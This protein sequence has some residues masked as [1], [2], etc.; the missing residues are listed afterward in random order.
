MLDERKREQRRHKRQGRYLRA[1]PDGLFRIQGR[2]RQ[3]IK[4]ELLRNPGAV[5]NLDTPFGYPLL[6]LFVRRE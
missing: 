2:L 6:V 5:C 3:F 1:G 4:R